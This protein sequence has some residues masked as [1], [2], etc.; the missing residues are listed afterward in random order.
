MEDITSTKAKVNVLWKAYEFTDELAPYMEFLE[1]VRSKSTKDVTSDSA[2]A[3]EE[4]MDK[5]DKCLNQID[6]RKKSV[7]DQTAKGE[8]VRCG[9]A[10]NY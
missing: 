4:L 6:Q 1:D 9:N 2:A 8:K 3:T 5:H 7:L 10:I